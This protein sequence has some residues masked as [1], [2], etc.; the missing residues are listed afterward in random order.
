MA[1]DKKVYGIKTPGSA[2]TFGVHGIFDHYP[3]S[4]KPVAA[5]SEIRNLAGLQL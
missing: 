1:F 2:R 3:K 4:R 5:Q